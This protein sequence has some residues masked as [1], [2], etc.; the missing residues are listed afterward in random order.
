MI[1][2]ETIKTAAKKLGFELRD[3]ELVEG[4]TGLMIRLEETIYSGGMPMSCKP[5]PEKV[6]GQLYK[7]LRRYGVNFEYRANYTSILIKA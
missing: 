4:Q 7:Y 6:K 1:K 5:M 3:V 2:L